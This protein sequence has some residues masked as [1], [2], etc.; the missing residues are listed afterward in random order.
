MDVVV[1]ETLCSSCC[2][3]YVC[4]H[5][6]DYLNM[7]QSLQEMFYELPKNEREF[8]YLKDPDCKFYSEQFTNPNPLTQRLSIPKNMAV[9]MADDGRKSCAKTIEETAQNYDEKT[10]V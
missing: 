10:D 4:A 5:K 7:V 8:M 6:N 2:H 9:A 1:R 3:R